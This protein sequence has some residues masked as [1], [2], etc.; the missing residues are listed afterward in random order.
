MDG[1]G[2]HGLHPESF[3]GLA[4]F[5]VVHDVLEDEFSLAAGI[6][7]I[8]DF[9]DVLELG[10][11]EDVAEA[12][13]GLFDGLEGKITGDGRKDVEIPRKVLSV[14]AGG[15]FELD[16]MTDRGGDHSLIVLEI[17]GITGL[18]LFGKLAEFFREGF[19]EICSNRGLLSDDQSLGHGP[20]LG[21]KG[22]GWEEISFR[23]PSF[24]RK[25]IE[26]KGVIHITL[27]REIQVFIK[28]QTF[29]R[30]SWSL[31]LELSFSPEMASRS[32]RR[33]LFVDFLNMD[34]LG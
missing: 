19:G 9:G 13:F 27:S 2:C 11:F 15:H 21:V 33:E 10:E 34:G 4:D 23:W 6:T 32:S 7:G 12:S 26:R 16:K 24:R 3:H 18:S 14:G 5:P 25:K 17:L 1:S 20:D 29:F 31:Q 28:N 8:H 30:C 22:G